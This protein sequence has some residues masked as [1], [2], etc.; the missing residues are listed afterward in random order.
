MGDR[1]ALEENLIQR[2]NVGD[3]LTRNACRF[4]RRPAVVDGARRFTYRDLNAWTNRVAHGLARRGYRRGD[5]LALVSENCAEFLVTYF[6]CAKLGVVCVPINLM[7]RQREVAYVLEHAQAKGV[8]VGAKLIEPLRPSLESLASPPELFVIEGEGASSFE[9]LAE[10]MPSNEP[11]VI[12]NDRDPVSYLYTSGTTSA[13]KGVVGNHLAIY[14]QTLNV[15]LE[16][17][18][19]ESDKAICI[20]PMFHTAQLNAGCTPIMAVGGALYTLR[21]FDAA[22]LLDLIEAER[23]T[24]AFCLPTMYRALIAE[25]TARPRD[26]SSLRL[27]VYGM[28]PIARNE[29]ERAMEVLG[30]EFSLYFGQTEMSPVTTYFRPEH[31]LS[32]AGAVGTPLANVQ[33]AIM[34]ADGNMLPQGASGEI[35]YRGPHALTGYLRNPEATEAVFRH[36]WFHSGDA[37]RIDED[38]ILWF[39]DRFKDVIKSGGENV[40]SLEVETAIYAVIPG[41]AEAAVVGLPH[42]KWGEAI[43]AVIVPKPGHAIVE[44]ETLA[45][46]RAQ[47]SPFKCP[48]AVIT[49]DALPKTATGKIQKVEVRKRFADYYSGRE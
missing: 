16:S 29:L 20:L 32:H 21:R 12:V 6:A 39:E 23:I 10:D 48:K 26:L 5:A 41:A 42:E 38:G 27:G 43:T 3:L 11:E 19:R 2:V 28:A 13:P 44:E 35:V 31:Q 7:W 8:V 4:P 49:V 24:V 14:I 46:L 33:V 18:F 36:G 22:A 34:D 17:G 40:A 9:A 30:C 37:G 47:L 25:Q 15:A 45:R 1:R